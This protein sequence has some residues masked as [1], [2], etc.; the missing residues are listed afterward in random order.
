MKLALVLLNWNGVEMLKRFLPD[1]IEY[2][3]RQLFM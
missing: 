2:S 1:L 3:K